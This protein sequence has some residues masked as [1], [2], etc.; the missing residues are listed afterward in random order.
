MRGGKRRQPRRLLGR[1][2]DAAPTHPDARVVCDVVGH[3]LVWVHHLH[4]Q[5]VERAGLDQAEAS[6]RPGEDQARVMDPR[7]ADRRVAE[8]QP[9]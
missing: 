1:Q 2:R 4:D 8:P 6:V 3:V 9:E 7:A 5:L